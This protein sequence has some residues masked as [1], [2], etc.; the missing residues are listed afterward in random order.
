MG[1]AVG[2][3]AQPLSW[4]T[5]GVVAQWIWW[6]SKAPRMAVMWGVP[7]LRS[8]SSSSAASMSRYPPV[9]PQPQ[10]PVATQSPLG[11]LPVPQVYQFV[12]VSAPR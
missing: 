9:A 2:P 7:L 4:T 12:T 10:V 8:P 5:G 6:R 1:A 3:P 11:G